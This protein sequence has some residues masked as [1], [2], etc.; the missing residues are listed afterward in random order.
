M[1]YNEEQLNTIR[2]CGEL[3]LRPNEVGYVLEL[4]INQVESDLNNKHTNAHMMYMRGK[5]ETK[6]VL[7][8][9]LL[10]NAKRGSPLAEQ[11]FNDLI[12]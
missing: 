2:K 6:M 1:I 4:D 5:M 8:E 9:N 10:K 3:L 11:I 12:K 7:R